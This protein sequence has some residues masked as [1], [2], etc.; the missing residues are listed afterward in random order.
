MH[1][2]NGS[3]FNGY[4]ISL[5]GSHKTKDKYHFFYHTLNKIVSND[6]DSVIRLKYD[7]QIMMPILFTPV[8]YKF[9]RAF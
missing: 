3:Y 8:K 7:Q 9:K 1:G 6:I 2:L 4:G 5:I